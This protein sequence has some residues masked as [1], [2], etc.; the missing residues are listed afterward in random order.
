MMKQHSAKKWEVSLKITPEIDS[1][2]MIK[3]TRLK[4]NNEII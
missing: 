2:G 1:S 4:Y 3:N